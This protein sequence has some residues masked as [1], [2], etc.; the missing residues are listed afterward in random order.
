MLQKLELYNILNKQLKNKTEGEIM[1]DAQ[2]MSYPERRIDEKLAQKLS[3]K[4]VKAKRIALTYYPPS[5]RS[6]TVTPPYILISLDD[7]DNYIRINGTLENFMVEFNQFLNKA[8]QFM[9]HLEHFSQMGVAVPDV[10]WFKMPPTLLSLQIQN[11]NGLNPDQARFTELILYNYI[12]KPQ[13]YPYIKSLKLY[14]LIDDV[15]KNMG[16]EIMKMFPNL[17]SISINDDE[18]FNGHTSE[19]YFKNININYHKWG[20]PHYGA[21]GVKRREIEREREAWRSA[22]EG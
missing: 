16:D 12:N 6:S 1:L 7:D 8:L 22:R 14:K 2:G 15:D 21:S 5:R 20:Y 4:F 17:E 9:N 18:S 3:N 13:R 10:K 11:I 19:A